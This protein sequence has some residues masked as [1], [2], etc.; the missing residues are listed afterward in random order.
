M[1]ICI[2]RQRFSGAVRRGAD[3]FRPCAA[4]DAEG[5][6]PYGVIQMMRRS[7]RPCGGAPGA[8]LQLRSLKKV[9][10]TFARESAFSRAF[11]FQIPDHSP[12]ILCILHGSL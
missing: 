2:L 1:I 12:E 4:R 9:V 7:A 10:H 5:G 8:A 3:H 11:P 6:V